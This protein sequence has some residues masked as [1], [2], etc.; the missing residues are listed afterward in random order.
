M[1]LSKMDRREKFRYL[2]DKGFK[3]KATMKNDE[4]DKLLKLDS[5]PEDTSSKERRGK[6]DRIPLG[7]HR[8]KMDAS[9]Y[10]NP[11]GKVRRWVNDEGGR[12]GDALE[13]GY[14]FIQDPKAEGKVGEDPLHTQ[15]MGSAVHIKVGTRD[16]GSPIH[17]YLMAIDEELYK[18]DQAFKM[19]Q[20]DEIDKAMQRGQHES[21]YSD[22]KYVPDG[23]IK[24]N[25]RG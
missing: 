9:S 1:D 22:G 12:I 16:D 3:C 6:K 14:E 17:G 23:G 10:P 13:G 24:Y 11:E 21:S 15:G 19:K 20:V 18:E 4:L 7:A 25:P 5:P 8:S 2:K